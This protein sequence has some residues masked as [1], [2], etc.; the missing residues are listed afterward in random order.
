MQFTISATNKMGKAAAAAAA[1]PCKAHFAIRRRVRRPRVAEKEEKE[2]EEAGSRQFSANKASL[3]KP[4]PCRGHLDAGMFACQAL[5][6]QVHL[7][8]LLL[9]YR[10]R[11]APNVV[12]R[13]PSP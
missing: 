1:A 8:L 4:W 5:R 13:G 11:L 2:E 3:C 6:L 9:R 12:E 10:M 7:L